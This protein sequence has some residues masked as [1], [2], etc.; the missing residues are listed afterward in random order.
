MKK[1]ESCR[2]RFLSLRAFKKGLIYIFRYVIFFS[3]KI[4][5]TCYYQQKWMKMKK[6]K[7]KV[8]ILKGSAFDTNFDYDYWIYLA[9]WIDCLSFFAT[10]F[11]L[12]ALKRF[13]IKGHPI[14]KQPP[15]HAAIL[16][17]PSL[18][19]RK[20]MIIRRKLVVWKEKRDEKL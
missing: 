10:T 5:R 14:S 9:A 3:V 7:I 19:V 8:V 18:L 16:F 12:T 11:I 20:K 6:K 2:S 15:S 1:K 17:F 4:L 13:V